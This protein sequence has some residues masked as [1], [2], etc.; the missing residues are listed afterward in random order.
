M[1]DRHV[2]PV[3]VLGLPGSPLLE[4]GCDQPHTPQRVGLDR[5]RHRC[6]DHVSAR[7][8][9]RVGARVQ[10][11]RHGPCVPSLRTRGERVHGVSERPLRRAG[12]QHAVPFECLGQV[13]VVGEYNG[14]PRASARRVGVR[15]EPLSYEFLCSHFSCSQSVRSMLTV[16]RRLSPRRPGSHRQRVLVQPWC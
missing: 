1:H 15:S 13:A 7:L 16:R 10:Q 5:P 12:G 9:S 14:P 11:H 4:R 2:A 6:R 3:L 8:P